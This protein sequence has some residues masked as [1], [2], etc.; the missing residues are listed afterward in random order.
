MLLKLYKIK[1]SRIPLYFINFTNFT[2]LITCL[3]MLEKIRSKPD[4]IK[5]IFSL[6][7]TVIIF[8]VIV[9]VWFSSSGA[10]SQMSVSKEKTVSPFASFMEM[11]QGIISDV[12]DKVSGMPMPSYQEI[13]TPIATSTQPRNEQEVSS[14][15]NFDTSGM[16]IID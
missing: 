9:F 13:Q 5:S 6:V 16:V 11:T 7:L 2:N 8:S 4:H 14:L 10:R 12:K 1:H 3:P 15:G